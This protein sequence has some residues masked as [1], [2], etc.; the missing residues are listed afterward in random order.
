VILI[1]AASAA[2]VLRLLDDNFKAIRQAGAELIDG[3]I[4]TNTMKNISNVPIS[5][6]DYRDM[7]KSS[8][9]GGIT[10][11]AKAMAMGIKALRNKKRVR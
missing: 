6:E 9:K 2:N 5:K 7:V 3:V 10:G 11:R 1:P 4:S 8:F